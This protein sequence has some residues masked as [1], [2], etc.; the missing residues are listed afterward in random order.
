[1]NAYVDFEFRTFTLKIRCENCMREEIMGVGVPDIAGA[2]TN[3][4]ELLE[5]AVLDN[6]RFHCRKCQG[7][8]GQIV[9]I[10]LGV[11]KL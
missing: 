9:D 4:E 8:I 11:V 10:G 6:T 2:P 7:V 3:V 1:M 5:S